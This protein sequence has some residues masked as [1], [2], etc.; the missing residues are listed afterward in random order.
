MCDVASNLGGGFHGLR[1]PQRYWD[2]RLESK[3]RMGIE[4][5]VLAAY[6]DAPPDT[7]AVAARLLEMQK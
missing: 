7:A 5:S 1:Q 6:L 3:F 2:S 4:A